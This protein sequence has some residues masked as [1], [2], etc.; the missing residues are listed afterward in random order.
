MP[1]Y[2]NEFIDG[3]KSRMEVSHAKYGPVRDAY[4]HKVSALDSLD[5]RLQKYLA[6]GNTEWLMDVAN[7]AM[8]E[9][10]C[11]SHPRAHF[12]ATD[13]NES[14]GRVSREEGVTKKDNEQLR[15]VDR[16]GEVNRG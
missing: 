9:F 14:P 12:R 5:K 4:P 7:F 8:I 11:P 1:E 15:T 2:S 6:T 10:M 13:T 16:A 3:M